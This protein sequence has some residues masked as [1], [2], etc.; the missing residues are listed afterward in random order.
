MA[1][2]PERWFYWL[3]VALFSSWFG[4]ACIWAVV[5]YLGFR[6]GGHTGAP[7]FMGLARGLNGVEIAA[8]IFAPP[9]GFLV[10]GY[11]IVTL[12]TRVR[13][14]HESGAIEG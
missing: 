1:K 13:E 11:L 4:F 14:K 10:V 7:G 8:A 6:L 3:K 5:W 12:L 9:L 2:N